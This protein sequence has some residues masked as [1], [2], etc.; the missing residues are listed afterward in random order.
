MTQN[1]KLAQATKEEAAVKA[2]LADAAAKSEALKLSDDRKAFVFDEAA[3]MGKARAVGDMS[4]TMTC[5]LYNDAVRLGAMKVEDANE[6]YGRYSGGYDAVNEKAAVFFGADK[7]IRVSTSADSL[8]EA[9]VN[10]DDAA[11]K[12]R[13]KVSISLVR[14]FAKPGCVAQGEKWFDRVRAIRTGIA[15]DDRAHGSMFNAW[16]AANRVANDT[17]LDVAVTDAMIIEALTKSAKASKKSAL[18]KLEKLVADTN[19]LVKTNGADF[20]GL[21][22]VAKVLADMARVAGLGIK[23]ELTVPTVT[24]TPPSELIKADD[25]GT[26]H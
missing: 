5:F 24:V 17:P 4:L 2:L 18:E 11:E 22:K 13:L 20:A 21:D 8:F 6:V 9:G 25:A 16:V 3:R 15:V 23:M 19:K 12:D 10:A 14:T 7:N 26:K 1:V